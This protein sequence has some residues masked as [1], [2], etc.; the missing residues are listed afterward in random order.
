MA[1]KP[2]EVEPEDEPMEMDTPA[3]AVSKDGDSKSAAADEVEK[4]SEPEAATPVAEDEKVPEVMAEAIPEEK[5]SSQL[6][7]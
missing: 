4:T 3:A 7:I 6:E 5:G 2:I 1:G